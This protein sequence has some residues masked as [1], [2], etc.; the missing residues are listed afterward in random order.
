MVAFE[1]IE[2]WMCSLWSQSSPKC[3]QVR[4]GGSAGNEPPPFS[5]HTH[6]CPLHLPSLYH[7]PSFFPWR[8]QGDVTRKRGRRFSLSK[9]FRELKDAD[10]FLFQSSRLKC[11]GRPPSAL[12]DGILIHHQV[13]LQKALLLC[14]YVCLYFLTCA[15]W[16]AT[17]PPTNRILLRDFPSARRGEGERFIE[18]ES[19]CTVSI[20]YS[21]TLR[22]TYMA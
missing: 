16:L 18:R 12:H 5:S 14:L 13:H 11:S 19:D 3:T 9:S 15:G 17:C 10:D 4:G 22:Q 1:C 8:L 6:S 7:F 21:F 2:A 20:N